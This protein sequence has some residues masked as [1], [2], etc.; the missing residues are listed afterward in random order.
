MMGIRSL[1]SGSAADS[2]VEGYPYFPLRKNFRWKDCEQHAGRGVLGKCAARRRFPRQSPSTATAKDRER[3]RAD[4]S[5]PDAWPLKN[6][7]CFSS[8]LCVAALRG[9]F[10][11]LN[12][13]PL[14]V[15]AAQ[16]G[17]LREVPPDADAVE[18]G[19]TLK[20]YRC[21]VG[22]RAGRRKRVRR[23]SAHAGRNLLDRFHKPDSDYH[24]A[25]HL[26]YPEQGD[27][28]GCGSRSLSRQATS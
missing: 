8:R 15:D 7:F 2:D 22:P 19:I 1:A 17:C 10:A 3:G 6:C 12:V 14:P 28:A 9:A 25:L 20:T 21:G 5:S 16:I 11:R 4:R 24:L 27:G 18:E 13:N 23:R 26:S